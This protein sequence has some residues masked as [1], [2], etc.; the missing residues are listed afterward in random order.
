MLYFDLD[1]CRVHAQALEPR[2]E[3]C[4]VWEKGVRGMFARRGHLDI[5]EASAG[6]V[7]RRLRGASFYVFPVT[8][9]PALLFAEADGPFFAAHMR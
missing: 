2:G 4:N 1:F 9:L 8:V 3:R 6:S 5:R 7:P